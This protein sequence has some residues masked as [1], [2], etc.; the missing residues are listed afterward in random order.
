M[1]LKLKTFS[2][3]NKN[4]TIFTL[5]TKLNVVLY[6]EIE[7]FFIVFTKSVIEKLK[8]F[9]LKN[10]NKTIL[11]LKTKMKLVLFFKLNHYFFSYKKCKRRTNNFHSFPKKQKKNNPN[12][13]P[14]TLF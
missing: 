13:D 9:S 6:F 3:K 8:T 7:P 11:T 4:K 5:K 10:K 2:L 12:T 14:R 1:Y